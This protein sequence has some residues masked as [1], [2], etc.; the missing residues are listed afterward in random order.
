M[1]RYGTGTDRKTPRYMIDKAYIE[2]LCLVI[3]DDDDLR[4]DVVEIQQVCLQ[5][6]FL[7]K[8][9]F[10]QCVGSTADLNPGRIRI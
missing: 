8:Y 10:K 2:Y 1:Y 9:T 3:S 7:K 4:N 6:D 5:S